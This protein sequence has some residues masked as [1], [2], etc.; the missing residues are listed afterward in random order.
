M[1]HC[2]T[3]DA[4]DAAL[5]GRAVNALDALD[6][7]L[8]EL[9][10]SVRMATLAPQPTSVQAI[11]LPS[12]PAPPVTTSVRLLKSYKLLISLRFISALPFWLRVDRVQVN[13]YESQGLPASMKA[14]NALR[15][16]LKTAADAPNIS[17]G[18]CNAALCAQPRWPAAWPRSSPQKPK[19]GPYLA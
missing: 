6:G 19:R 4:G 7:A 10:V 16:L 12:T 5:R 2:S 11:S 9:R 18:R 14:V 1:D 17:S 3:P 13:R 8:G 15:Q